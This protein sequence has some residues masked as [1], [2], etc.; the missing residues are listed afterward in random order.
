[1]TILTEIETKIIDEYFIRYNIENITFGDFRLAA[2]SFPTWR[3][4]QLC[5]YYNYDNCT[6]ELSPAYVE[7]IENLFKSSV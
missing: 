6:T 7:Y 1:M 5:N 4:E 3:N 2:N